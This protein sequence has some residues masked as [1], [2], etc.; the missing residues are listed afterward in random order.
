MRPGGETARALDDTI[1]PKVLAWR[2][3]HPDKASAAPQG[4]EQVALVQ[5]APPVVQGL[6]RAA[7]VIGIVGEIARQQIQRLL[8]KDSS[9]T[10]PEDPRSRRMIVTEPTPP[11]PPEDPDKHKPDIKEQILPVRQEIPI[12]RGKPINEVLKTDPVIFEAVSDKLRKALEAALESHPGDATTKKGNKLSVRYCIDEFHK[13]WG[14]GATLKH[15]GGAGK[16]ENYRRSIVTGGTKGSSHP[17]MTLEGKASPDGPNRVVDLNSGRTLK[18]GRTP[19]ADERRQLEKLMQNLN[20]PELA[21]V[22]AGFLPKLRPNMVQ[23]EWE[24]RVREM[25]KAALIEAFGEP[26]NKASRQ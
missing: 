22:T 14:P 13:G 5:L 26:P 23:A 7:P 21:N 15:V 24:G 11:V 6:M 25:C 3:A 18:D 10:P 1:A 4:D 12:F 8:P 2:A 9:D 20:V 16:R 19:I 17:D